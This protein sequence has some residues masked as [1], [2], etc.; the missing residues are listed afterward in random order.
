MAT[1]ARELFQPVKCL[2]GAHLRTY[3]DRAEMKPGRV[4]TFKKS[5]RKA[6][7]RKNLAVELMQ[8]R[9]FRINKKNYGPKRASN[10][11]LIDFLHTA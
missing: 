6:F 10:A 11:M 5:S 9:N 1:L 2:F 7:L 4:D 8:S 3:H